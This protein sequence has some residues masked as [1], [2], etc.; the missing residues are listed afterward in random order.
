MREFNAQEVANTAWALATMGRSKQVRELKLQ[1]LIA[2]Q[3]AYRRVGF[4]S[5]VFE[6]QHAINNKRAE[7]QGDKAEED[8]KLTKQRLMAMEMR[9]N[10]RA[11][12]L[13]QSQ[14]AETEKLIDAQMRDYQQL[15]ERQADE[16]HQLVE[17][18]TAMMT[19]GASWTPVVQGSPDQGGSLSWA[20]QLKKPSHG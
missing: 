18:V 13:Q 17:N 10:K 2:E 15:L 1:D 7:G 5:E 4:T 8:D 14:Q 19:I 9:Q 11:A 20:V 12:E 3:R 16:M 6:L